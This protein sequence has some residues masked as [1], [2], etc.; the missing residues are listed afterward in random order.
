MFAA[1]ESTSRTSPPNHS[2][3][4]EPLIL[5][6]SGIRTSFVSSLRP[7]SRGRRPHEKPRRP[8]PWPQ[9]C[10]RIVSMTDCRSPA[11]PLFQDGLEGVLLS[12]ARTDTQ[13]FDR[14][15]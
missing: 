15:A 12:I 14:N 9:P 4:L 2:C 11:L 5:A 13:P 1:A 3:L 7:G 6:Y 8:F 10:S